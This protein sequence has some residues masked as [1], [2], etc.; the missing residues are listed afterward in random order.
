MALPPKYGPT[1]LP[2][3]LRGGPQRVTRDSFFAMQRL[4]SVEE[5]FRLQGMDAVKTNE[6]RFLR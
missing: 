3:A 1:P 2:S 6:T 5:I 4:V